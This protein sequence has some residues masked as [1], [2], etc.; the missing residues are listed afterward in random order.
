M[1]DHDRHAAPSVA[2]FAGIAIAPII[3]D[4]RH[5]RRSSATQDTHLHLSGCL[6]EQGV[7]VLGR[8][9]GKSFDPLSPDAGQEPG[10]VGDERRLA[11][12]AAV[13]NGRKEG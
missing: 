1:L 3:A 6:A 10:G 5:S 8:L 2:R 13:R 12:A 9:P 4:P 7:E 11:R